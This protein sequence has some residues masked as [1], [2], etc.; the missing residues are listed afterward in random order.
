VAVQ[1]GRAFRIFP[2]IVASLLLATIAVLPTP[3]YAVTFVTAD[4]AGTWQVY[5]FGDA[6]SPANLP[7]WRRVQISV[8]SVGTVSPGAAVTFSDGTPSVTVSSGSLSID[9]SGAITGFVAF[10]SG[11][12]ITINTGQAQMDAAKTFVSGVGTEA[13]NSFQELIVAI[14]TGGSFA[15]TDLGG[16]WQIYVFGDDPGTNNNPGW[17]YGP[18]SVGADG[19]IIGGSS[20]TRDSGHAAV[21]ITGNSLSIDPSGL[22]TGTIALNNGQS[23]VLTSA[24]MDMGKTL[25][26]GNI[27]GANFVGIITGVKQG[28]DPKSFATADLAGTWDLSA[29]GDSPKPS[30]NDAGASSGSI[31]VN[32]SGTVTGGSTTGLGAVSGGMLTMDGTSG[33]ISGNI[34]FGGTNSTVFATMHAGKTIVTGVEQD[35]PDGF[36]DTIVAIKTAAASG[37]STLGVTRTGNG[38]GKVTSDVAGIACGLACTASFTT[39]TS[40]TLTA[41]ANPGTVFTG[42]GGACSGTGTCTVSVT[43]S[44]NV[45]ANFIQGFTVSVVRTGAGSGSVSSNPVGINCGTTCSFGFAAGSSV[46]LTAT[47][48]PG[49]VFIGWSGSGIVCPGTGTC[50]V[51]VTHATAISADFDLAA[52]TLTV[53]L[54]GAGVGSVASSPAGISCGATCE[55]GFSNGTL[56]SLTATPAGSVF[57]GWSG[58]GC[59]GTGTCTVTMTAAVSVTARFSPVFTDVALT[60]GTLIKAVHVMELRTAVNNLRARLGLGAFS[61][62]DVSLTAGATIAQ[63][64][65]ILELRAA[66]NEVYDALVLSR[67]SYNTDPSLAAGTTIKAAHITE[68]RGSVTAP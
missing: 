21:M 36:I 50:Q 38:S 4:L 30:V 1:T 12:S 53:T 27:N 8:N 41:T 14:K 16:S 20:L 11:G 10:S 40:V 6:P 7:G 65:H 46:T 66:L 34:T 33:V 47:A 68:L 60:A 23:V 2:I 15:T 19:T 13:N 58:G 26:A 24:K 17:Y 57:V 35:A 61:F 42:W 63:A 44:V 67:P 56:V 28:N 55:F 22:M 59:S 49:S 5:T 64:V 29:F 32:A 9:P 43:G 37:L 25:F 51:T 45:T 62:A 52:K 39:G 48:D 3:G 18:I 31:T 54:K